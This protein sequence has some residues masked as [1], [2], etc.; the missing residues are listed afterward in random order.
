MAEN[1]NAMMKHSFAFISFVLLFAGCIS[2]YSDVVETTFQISSTSSS[3]LP[4][5][6]SLSTSS[7]TSSTLSQFRDTTTST[8]LMPAETFSD[9]VRAPKPGCECIQWVCPTTT[10]LS[11]QSIVSTSSTTSTTCVNVP[12]DN[13]ESQTHYYSVLLK[14]SRFKPDSINAFVGDTIVANISNKQGLHRLT[15]T[16]SGK[17]IT[18]LPEKNY[19]L[20]FYA[21]EE[22]EHLLTCNP[23]CDE[24]MELKIIVVPPYGKVC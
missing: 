16:Y 3:I 11:F 19:E 8:T 14:G 2:D 4:T 24:P 22:G 17:I 10:T 9:Y 23:F 6:T 13:Y 12:L 15:E 20:L 7:T 18:M 21:I 1:I 5:T